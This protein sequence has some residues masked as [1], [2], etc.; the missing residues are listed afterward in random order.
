MTFFYIC[1]KFHVE[2]LFVMFYAKK[3][4]QWSKWD[5]ENIF[6]EYWF[7]FFR[8]EHRKCHFITIFFTY[9]ENMGMFVVTFFFRILRNVLL[10]KKIPNR[11]GAYELGSK[12]CNPIL[13]WIVLTSRWKFTGMGC[14]E[15]NSLI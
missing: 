5:F 14:D 10:F 1:A 3:K 8:R 9:I 15:T 6:S 2:I 13:E 4:N 7:C 12:N 11:P